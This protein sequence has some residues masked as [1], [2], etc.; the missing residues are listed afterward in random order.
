MVT[1]INTKIRQR[2]KIADWFDSFLFSLLAVSVV[3]GLAYITEEYLT[4]GIKLFAFDWGTAWEVLEGIGLTAAIGRGGYAVLRKFKGEEKYHKAI[5][6]VLDDAPYPI[7][8][9][10]VK[11]SVREEIGEPVILNPLPLLTKKTK[12]SRRDDLFD[13]E[14]DSVWIK[15]RETGIIG[16][17]VGDD[18]M[19]LYFFNENQSKGK[20]EEQ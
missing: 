19:N 8:K 7:P 15:M 9:E 10:N 3:I 12:Q 2:D 18:G 20:K 13:R 17:K 5:S 4:P 1:N 11:E 16:R 6:M 14:F